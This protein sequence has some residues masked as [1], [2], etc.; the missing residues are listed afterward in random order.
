[1]KKAIG[2]IMLV[3]AG[4]MIINVGL[5]S[6]QEPNSIHGKVIDATTG[7]PIE[8]VVV[9]VDDVDPVLSDIT[10]DE[11]EYEIDDVPAGSQ[12]ITASADGYESETVGAEV[13]ETDG[14]TVNFTLQPLNDE[15]E[16]A[17]LKVK[18]EGGKTAGTRR[19]YVG[20]FTSTP[21]TG[22]PPETFFVTPKH[23]EDIEIQIPVGGL[24][25][26]TKTPGRPA[27]SLTDESQ[28]AVLVE[29]VDEG[30]SLVRVAQRIIV[31]PTPQAH[32]L[33]G[34]VSIAVDEN[35][36][37]TVSIMRHNGAIKELELGPDAELPEVGDLV[38]AFQGRASGRA[39]GAGVQTGTPV[40]KGLVRAEK[41]R[42]RL[43]GFLDDLTT[44]EGELPPQAADRR[45][46]RV[47]DIAA[48]LEDHASKHVK[49]IQRVSQN[50]NL[51]PRA[52]A[53]L[54][55][56]LQR[57]QDGL[58][59]A[60]ARGSEAKTKA[61]PPSELEGQNQGGRGNQR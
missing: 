42:Q 24:A 31:K 26:I 59:G 4:L 23:G 5:I 14:A 51:P 18:N 3:I 40:A 10:N 16:V 22:A 49:I 32:I 9:A 45:A 17:E 58:V 21:V 54:Q 47:A 57:A 41:V 53:G 50:G 29:F 39:S 20:I 13:S 38:T 61:G 1:M 6:A 2:I 28:V 30:E 56:G 48:I 60:Q 37:R 46:Q 52:V 27:G 7:E 11:G 44:E 19:G 35:G 36:V 43:E 55:N 34:V 33:G 8:N 25:S 15:V 12:T